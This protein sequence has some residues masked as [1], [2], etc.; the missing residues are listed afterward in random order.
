MMSRTL[1]ILFVAIGLFRP[2]LS[3][4]GAIKDPIADFIATESAIEWGK[5][6][7]ISRVQVDLNRDGRKI[8]FL[9]NSYVRHAGMAWTVY[10]P[11]RRGYTRVLTNLTEE[12]MPCFMPENCHVGYIPE[13]KHRG[14]VF[15]LG[16]DVDGISFFAFWVEDGK[17]RVKQIGHTKPARND[18]EP[19]DPLFR[20]YFPD[21]ENPN[22]KPPFAMET[23]SMDDLRAKGYAISK[24]DP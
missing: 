12:D 1:A 8:V 4:A 7:D 3:H 13:I 19:D 15:F 11:A 22:R 17:A 10:L 14:I 20:K 21:L 16:R 9:S 6:K 18:S 2:A 23:L 24:I 5:Y